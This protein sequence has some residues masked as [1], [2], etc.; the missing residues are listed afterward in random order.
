[1]ES[2]LVDPDFILNNTFRDIITVI[3]PMTFISGCLVFVMLAATTVRGMVLFAI[4]YGFFSGACKSFQVL[5]SSLPLN[6][7]FK[8]YL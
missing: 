6:Q 7:N 1:M 2:S 3:I 4:F 8:L 5:P